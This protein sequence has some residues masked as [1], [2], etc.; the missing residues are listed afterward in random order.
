MGLGWP[1]TRSQMA[2]D[3]LWRCRHAGLWYRSKGL[4]SVQQHK[5]ALCCLLVVQY[6][7]ESTQYPG[8]GDLELSSDLGWTSHPIVD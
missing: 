8:F 2:S 4:A 1:T 6:G 3:I 7:S 5:R